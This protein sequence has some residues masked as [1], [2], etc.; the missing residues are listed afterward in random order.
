VNER[1]FLLYINRE[2]CQEEKGLIYTFCLHPA[3]NSLLRPSAVCLHGGG[4]DAKQAQ[5][6]IYEG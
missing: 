4:K 2:I 1:S 5:G 3:L 6:R